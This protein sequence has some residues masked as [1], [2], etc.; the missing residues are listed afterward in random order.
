MLKVK[1]ITY[2]KFCKNE[3]SK[4]SMK[5]CSRKCAD[6]LKNFGDKIT[7]LINKSAIDSFIFNL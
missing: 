7:V 6:E 1:E 2:C 5:T 3:N 4:S